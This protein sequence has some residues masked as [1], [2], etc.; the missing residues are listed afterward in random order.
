MHLS[1]G[2]SLQRLHQPG[3]METDRECCAKVL[4]NVF[5]PKRCKPGCEASNRLTLSLE[6]APG[7]ED[8]EK[9]G[10]GLFFNCNFSNLHAL[11]ILMP[12]SDQY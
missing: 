10:L 5:E 1:L 9:S 3:L 11:L 7:L 8:K 2:I 4:N 6:C 12:L